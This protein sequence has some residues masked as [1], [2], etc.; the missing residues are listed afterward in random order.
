MA[1]ENKGNPSPLLP[2]DGQ[3]ARPQK[4]QDFYFYKEGR[5]LIFKKFKPG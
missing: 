5:G 3:V 1:A 2:R 4:M